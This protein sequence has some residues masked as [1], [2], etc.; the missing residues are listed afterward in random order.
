[1]YIEESH[2]MYPYTDDEKQQIRKELGLKDNILQEDIDSILEWY[3]KQPHLAGAPINRD[4]VE[5]MFIFSKCSREKTKKKIDHFYKC[6]SVAPEIIETRKKV[7]LEPE[8][9]LWTFYRQAAMLKL[10][11]GKRI[12]IFKINDADP[13]SFS[14]EEVYRNTI[15][16]GDLRLK[17]D[18]VLGDIWIFDLKNVTLGHILRV[19][20]T[21]IQ[22]FANIL[23]DGI[24]IKLYEIHVLNTNSL[25]QHL[26]AFFK[27]FMKPKIFE[28][29]MFHGND[30]DLQTLIPKI[31]LPKDYG[32]DQPSLEEFKDMYSKELREDI[33]RNYLI[34]CCEQISNEK[35]RPGDFKEEYLVGS[36]KKLDLD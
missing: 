14:N 25:T 33:T 34:E 2:P 22:K 13:S 32:G 21:L 20:V 31:Y 9:V 35:L 12:S 24:G 4:F 1:M 28:R 29:I 17:F 27:Q 19:N 15:M 8:T 11:N 23:Q 18:Y 30:E 36:F 16:L 3:Y 26:M 6:R 10:Y 5:K 7:L